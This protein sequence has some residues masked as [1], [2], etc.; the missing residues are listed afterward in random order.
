MWHK[1]DPICFQNLTYEF[2]DNNN[3]FDIVGRTID[4]DVVIAHVKGFHQYFYV[5]ASP[6]CS[7]RLGINTPLKLKNAI[8]SRL[9]TKYKILEVSFKNKASFYYYK[10]NELMQLYKIVLEHP[11]LMYKAISVCRDI[12]SENG[13]LENISFY[14]A[15]V[16]S[17]ETKFIVDTYFEASSW[18]ILSN[19]RV[20]TRTPSFIEIECHY[21]NFLCVSGSRGYNLGKDINVDIKHHEPEY[22]WESIVPQVLLGFDIEC[23]SLYQPHKFPN[24]MYDPIIQI[25]VC[26]K[27]TGIANNEFKRYLFCVLD[28]NDDELKDVEIHS[29]LT[30]FEML[31][32]FGQFV[33]NV[34]PDILTG[35]N[36]RNFD[37]LYVYARALMLNCKSL[38]KNVSRI[39][40]KSFCVTKK[41]R[42]A[43][44][45]SKLEKLN[46][47][48]PGRYILDIFET[49][50][51]QGY[52]LRSK[53]LDFV[54][55][56]FLKKKKLDM[57]YHLIPVKFLESKAG[58]TE[59][60]KYCV[61][62]TELVMQLFDV[63]SVLV[64]FI[65]KSRVFGMSID[66]VMTSGQQAKVFTIM[67]KVIRDEALPFVFPMHLSNE[68]S[69]KYQGAFVLDPKIGY[70]SEAHKII[71]N[72]FNSLYPTI[73]M[74]FNLCT[75]TMLS[76]T[77]IQEYFPDNSED[78][79]IIPELNV[80]FVSSKIKQGVVPLTLQILIGKRNDVKKQMFELKNQIDGE[81][82]DETITKLKLNH[83]LLDQR[84]NAL[85]I[86][87]NTMYG[88]LGASNGLLPCVK[89]AS[90]VTY[91]GRKMLITLK[92]VIE[93]EIT[94]KNGYETNAEVI[95]GDT[96]STFTLFR[97][98]STEKAIEYGDIIS[99]VINGDI[100]PTTAEMALKVQNTFKKPIA[101]KFECV[102]SP[103]L[104]TNKKKYIGKMT[105]SLTST[106]KLLT[107]GIETKRRDSPALINETLNTAI[108]YIFMENDLQKGIDSIKRMLAA[109]LQDGGRMTIVPAEK[110]IITKGLVKWDYSKTAPPHMQ[111]VYRLSKTGS[112]APKIGDR[113]SFV[114]KQ[115]L[116]GY[117]T[118]NLA[119][120]IDEIIKENSY[121]N[122]EYYVDSLKNAAMRIFKFLYKDKESAKKNLF[123][124]SHMKMKSL[125]TL[126]KIPRISGEID[127]GAIKY[128]STPWNEFTQTKQQMTLN[129]FFKSKPHPVKI[130][131][132]KKITKPL[133][134]ANI[135][136]F[137]PKIERLGQM[138]K[139]NT[140]SKK[141]KYTQQTQIE[142]YFSRAKKS[143][144]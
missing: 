125:S 80:A 16:P 24:W 90:A 93:E 101:I 126:S 137:F 29:S 67:C 97:N 109:L 116:K 46:V 96:D 82:C 36:I 100:Q 77:D 94:Q 8:N 118:G 41:N 106:P 133:K 121:I 43:N 98:V 113:I 19:Y 83:V 12:L 61:L 70:F 139:D 87:A 81:M 68:K 138:F 129:Q 10:N 88:L 17:F 117:S 57:P 74:A 103:F 105:E 85:K 54:S 38:F 112:N 140:A 99:N 2:D 120:T 53:K 144:S 59:I 92:E 72:D 13:L 79:I 91:L 50:T 132:D 4:E 141:R 134:Q 7:K 51:A 55:F 102:L 73:M 47:S 142:A 5:D 89:I 15:D 23:A 135:E 104:I 49:I 84:Q 28:C 33:K 60:A 37:L 56:H 130:T 95:Y 9:G 27:N 123:S 18:V 122:T 52:K 124:G 110:Y 42:F 71:V 45:E 78:Y 86:C 64:D 25:S 143:K 114:I 34:D 136:K 3:H 32:E 44:K 75:S 127:W 63:T 39:H 22:G 26:V 62:D 30:E 119:A 20:I 35:Y 1:M 115:G 76:I 40:G 14:N 111:V 65:V 108:N 69:C 48:I 131:S 21:L 107:K 66:R 31:E 11:S 128:I 58:R 6:F